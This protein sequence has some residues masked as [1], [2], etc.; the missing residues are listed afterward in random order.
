[1]NVPATNPSHSPAR[2]RLITE[3]LPLA[4]RIARKMGRRADPSVREDVESSAMLG[5]VEAANRYDFARLE[6][7]AAFAYRRIQG[8]IIDGMRRSD[9][10]PRRARTLANRANRVKGELEQK[11]G[12]RPEDAEMAKHL[13]VSVGEY[14]DEIRMLSEVCFVE[15]SPDL[16]HGARPEEEAIDGVE[17]ARRIALVRTALAKLEERD[18]Q[19]LSLYYAEDLTYAEI[20]RLLGVSEARICQ[21]HSRAI[22]RLRAELALC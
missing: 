2:Q 3:H 7:F 9:I 17:R 15:L 1:M 20:G 10:L 6:P 13:E 8:A 12:R 19:I 11:L 5:L 21:L 16:T 4:R 18:Q 14:R 22:K